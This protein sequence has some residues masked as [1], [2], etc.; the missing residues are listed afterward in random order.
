[1][2]Y[3]YSPPQEVCTTDSNDSARGI[4]IGLM[5]LS[6]LLMFG[7]I[8]IKADP[9]SPAERQTLIDAYNASLG[10]PT[11]EAA[12]ARPRRA[13]FGLAVEPTASATSAGL[14]LDGR[15]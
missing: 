3:R 15:F 1:M 13:A 10:P 11:T 7:S 9:V 2:P 6:P 4:G 8:G 12:P 5:V 14:T